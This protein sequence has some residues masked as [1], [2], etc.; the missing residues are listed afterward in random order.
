MQQWNQTKTRFCPKKHERSKKKIIDP[1]NKARLKLWPQDYLTVNQCKKIAVFFSFS[2]PPPNIFWPVN[3]SAGLLPILL[4][5][6]KIPTNNPLPNVRPSQQ[7]ALRPRCSLKFTKTAPDPAWSSPKQLPFWREVLNMFKS[8][9]N[10]S[11]ST[12]HPKNRCTHTHRHI[13]ETCQRISYLFTV[14]VLVYKYCC[15]HKNPY[16]H[17]I[18]LYI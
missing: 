5:V 2:A 10:D 17:N 6:C 16:I 13:T 7:V 11:S 9:L 4:G 18:S 14:V 15:K 8:S 12:K 1:R 3:S